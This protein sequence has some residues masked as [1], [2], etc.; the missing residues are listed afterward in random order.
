MGDNPSLIVTQEKDVSGISSRVKLHS[1]CSQSSCILFLNEMSVSIKGICW[2]NLVV[3]GSCFDLILG[4][5]FQ[6]TSTELIEVI[7]VTDYLPS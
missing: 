7:P 6:S 1:F 4:K 2:C 3:S 5:L